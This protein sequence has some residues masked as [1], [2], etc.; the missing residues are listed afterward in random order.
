M[1]RDPRGT[2]THMTFALH[3]TRIV[4]GAGVAALVTIGVSGCSGDSG[5]SGP[6]KLGDPA[7]V[8]STTPTSTTAT[9]TAPTASTTATATPS[10]PTG[11]QSPADAA[12]GLYDAWK[13]NDKAKAATLATPE[14]VAGIFATVPGDYALYNRCD[15]GEFG[16]SGCLFRSGA[17][18]ATIQFNME[19][20]NGAWVVIDA[21]YQPR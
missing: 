7:T 3:L 13:A 18:Y 19:Q 11:A 8:T 21:V 15:T 16:T 1:W 4:L 6:T 17:T 9:S 5:G 12:E 20:R 10:E 2:V 14:A